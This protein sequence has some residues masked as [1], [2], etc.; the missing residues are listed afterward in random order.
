MPEIYQSVLALFDPT[1]LLL[2]GM[3]LAR[4]CGLV[5]I[6]PLYGAREV[7]M[8]ARAMFA[9]ALA[10]LILPTQLAA[11]AP[12]PNTLLEFLTYV[13]TEV[14]VGYVLSLGIWIMFSALQIAGQVIGQTSG[15]ALADVFNPGLDASIP[16]AAQ[17][18]YMF[19]LAIWLLAGGHRLAMEGFLATFSE[20]PPGAALDFAVIYQTLGTLVANS[21]ELGI[22]VAGPVVAAL[23]LSTLVMGLISRTLPQLNIIAVGFSVNSMA[24]LAMLSLT[25]GVV[26]Y[27]FQD[28]IEPVVVDI[29][30]GLSQSV[31]ASSA[32][33][34]AG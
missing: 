12:T 30:Q 8:R 25:L 19:G 9:V 23:L 3:L 21:L 10:I 6:G 14:A 32:S 34:G 16:L 2:F 26:G 13:A 11:N 4:T 22:R 1:K 7:P 17:F 24:S 15:M 5:L 18:L 31:S 33:T 20:V 27:V 29:V 28:E